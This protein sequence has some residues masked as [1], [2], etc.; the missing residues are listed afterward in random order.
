MIV[1]LTSTLIFLFYFLLF[2]YGRDT[3][4]IKAF[5][6]DFDFQIQIQLMFNFKITSPK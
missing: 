4:L 5:F 6:L 2:T 1:T 3:L